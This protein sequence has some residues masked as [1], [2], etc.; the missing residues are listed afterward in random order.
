MVHSA[1]YL[2]S[3][4]SQLA[5]CLLKPLSAAASTLRRYSQ[6][7]RRHPACDCSR[8]YSLSADAAVA[9]LQHSA[10]CQPR[11]NPGTC[12]LHTQPPSSTCG[13]TW[14]A[15]S[16]LPA[17]RSHPAC[18]WSRA[19]SLPAAAAVTLPLLTACSLHKQPSAW[20]HMPCE[21]AQLP[22]QP[23]PC[24]PKPPSAR[25]VS[26][27]Q[28]PSSSCSHTITALSLLPAYAALSL[29]LRAY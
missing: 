6:L 15:H 29:L 9:L 11:A 28:P 8:A 12:L 7:A 5:T 23:A 4:A 17:C 21:A 19:Y 25:L 14:T 24:L 16:L 22:P 20:F 13:H 18:N 2:P 3:Y 10:T 26:S 1:C 27:T